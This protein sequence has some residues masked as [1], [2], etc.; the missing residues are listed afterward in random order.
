MRADPGWPK[1][2]NNLGESELIK[3]DKRPLKMSKN[4][5]NCWTCGIGMGRRKNG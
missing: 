1:L 4:E 5:D 2:S 3:I